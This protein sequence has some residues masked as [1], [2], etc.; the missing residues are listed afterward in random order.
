MIQ[1]CL[2]EDSPKKRIHICLLSAKEKKVKN[3]LFRSFSLD[4]PIA[5]YSL[6]EFLIM[7]SRAVFGITLTAVILFTILLVPASESK[8]QS[9]FESGFGY[10]YGKV[11]ICHAPPGNPDNQHTITIGTPAVRA[12]LDHGDTLGTCPE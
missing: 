11:M 8:P 6:C 7:E 1:A 12:H 9:D 3:C 2:I 10:G 5:K 4:E